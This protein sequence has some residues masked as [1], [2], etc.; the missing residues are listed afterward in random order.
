[1][2]SSIPTYSV[3]LPPVSFSI[4]TF[5]CRF[6]G[7]GQMDISLRCYVRSVLSGP[8][9]WLSPSPNTY[10]SSRETGTAVS[11]HL[12]SVMRFF[13]FFFLEWEETHQKTSAVRLDWSWSNILILA[14]AN[15]CQTDWIWIWNEQ[16]PML[17]Y[18]VSL[19]K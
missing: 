12:F 14:Y 8:D 15:I 11:T 17:N 4:P 2:T 18:I 5:W 7:S 13:F 10:R 1:M 9:L 19:L 16:I 3:A 6:L